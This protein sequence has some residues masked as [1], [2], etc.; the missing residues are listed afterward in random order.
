MVKG[1]FWGKR[2]LLLGMLQLALAGAAL[3]DEGKA[4]GGVRPEIGKPISAALELLK[5]K[6]GKDSL[7]KVR[8]SRFLKEAKPHLSGGREISLTIRHT[9]SCA[10][11]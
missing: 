6:K 1:W 2:L 8:E 3:A 5:A 9:I 11:A 7:A 10:G 4:A